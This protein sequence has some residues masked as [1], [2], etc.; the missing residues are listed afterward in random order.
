M[1]HP[2]VRVKFKSVLVDSHSSQRRT[3][4]Q[5]FATITKHSLARATS[6]TVRQSALS[7]LLPNLQCSFAFH[8]SFSTSL[9]L[10]TS[11]RNK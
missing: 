1:K 11:S 4:K 8:T 2:F 6:R 3:N 9:D 7:A 10:Y 5:M